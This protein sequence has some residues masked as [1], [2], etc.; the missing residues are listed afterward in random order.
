MR[1][2]EEAWK[3]I[4]TCKKWKPNGDILRG[5]NQVLFYFFSEAIEKEKLVRQKLQQVEKR[6]LAEGPGNHRAMII[7]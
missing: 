1:R 4:E 2:K 6:M 7:I 5:K 3:G